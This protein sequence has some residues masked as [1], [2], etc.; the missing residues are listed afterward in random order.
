MTVH[1]TPYGQRL[2]EAALARG[3]GRSP[4]EIIERAL[5]AVRGGAATSPEEERERRSAVASMLAFQEEFHLTL[6]PGEHV[7]DLIREGSKY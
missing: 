6:G 3:G 2:L 7:Q 4:E 1:L 5:E